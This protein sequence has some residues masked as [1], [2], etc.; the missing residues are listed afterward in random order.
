MPLWTPGARSGTLPGPG[1]IPESR[2]RDD[3]P[4]RGLRLGIYLDHNATTPVRPEVVDAMAG[5]LAG[6]PGNPSS[7]HAWGQEARRSRER[8]RERV[9]AALGVSPNRVCFTSGGTEADNLAL[10][11]VLGA[12]GGRHLIVGATEHEAVLHTAE[13]LATTGGVELTILPVESDGRIEAD[14]LREALRPETALVSI[15]AANNETGVLADLAN[16]GGICREHGVPFHSDGVQAFGKIPLDLASLP[17]DL[18]SISAHKLGGPKGCGALVVSPDIRLTPLQTG[19]GQERQVRPGTENLPGIVGFGK[20]A[21][22]AHEELSTEGSRLAALRDRLEAGIREAFPE[23][24]INGLDAPRLPNTSNVS[25]PG[26]DGES[27]MIALDLEGV[28]V[29]TGAACNAGAS[30]PSH[31]L[32]AMGRTRELAGASLRF[33][34]GRTTR[35]SE[36]VEVLRILPLLV[37]RSAASGSA[38]EAVPSNHGRNP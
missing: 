13:H 3:A 14:T 9:A 1:R 22:L 2:P 19:G 7:R 36:I 27:L 11:G 25:F 15:M 28:A 18:L 12:G 34:L 5:S 21:E 8:A 29:S 35:E 4:A 10:R 6:Q 24:V 23:A 16:L 37:R 26:R 30:D 20:A 32:L 38:T 33:S 31:V 17:V